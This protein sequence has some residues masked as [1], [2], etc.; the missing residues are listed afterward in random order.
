VLTP[1]NVDSHDFGKVGFFPVDG[2]VDAQPLYVGAYNIHGGIHNVLIVATEHDSVYALDADSGK[3]YWHVSLLKTGETTS[4]AVH[5]CSQVSPEIGITSTPVIDLAMG[6]N[7]TVFAVAMSKKG[8]SYFQRLHA[9]DLLTG[10]ES[11]PATTI[12]ADYPG[13]GDASSSGVVPFQPRQYKERAGLLLVNGVIYTTWASHCDDQPYTGWIIAYDEATLAR[14]AVLNIAPNGE[15]A[16]IWAAGAAPAADAA[17][18]IYFLAANGTF[19]STLDVNGFPTQGDYGN[20]FMKLSTSGGT[21]AVADYFNMH[22]TGHESFLDQDLGSGGAMLLPD[23]KDGAGHVKHLAVGAGKDARIYVVDRDNMGKFD[24]ATDHIW[25]E[26]PNGLGDGEFGM[27]AYFN[28]RVYYGAVNDALR[29]FK[30]SK[31]KLS[32]Q[33]E[34]Q[35]AHDF[36]YPG[37]TPGISAR[38]TQDGI[39]WATENGPTAGLYA[40]DATN[41][42]RELYDS[43]QAGSRDQFGTG[44]KFITPTIANGKVYVGT[45]DGIAV[46][47][48]LR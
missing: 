6:A 40:F 20:A 7:G 48:L 25:Q 10:A 4:D 43:N 24:P 42:G 8:S 18:N 21:L 46:F 23:M 14:S 30:V 3:Q 45:T 31:A 44:N 1:A 13:T 29:A 37:A 2:R 9:L 35:S 28:L 19:E 38:G 36:Q 32:T 16:S 17:G 34:S 47:G 15:G 41:V 33:P 22:D 12:Q 5:G 11:S 27:P 39:V 26:L